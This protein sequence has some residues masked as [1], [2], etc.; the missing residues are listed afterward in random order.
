MR[1]GLL[2]RAAEP[3]D[4]LN[5]RLRRQR[6]QGA[7]GVAAHGSGGGACLRG[8]S[9][10]AHDELVL[11]LGDDHVLEHLAAE[12]LAINRHDLVA[13][14]QLALRRRDAC[15]AITARGERP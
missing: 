5:E 8:H 11:L 9:R 15:S 1:A 3:Y 10:V 13:V 6:R 2:D 4:G 12:R 14:L 7:A